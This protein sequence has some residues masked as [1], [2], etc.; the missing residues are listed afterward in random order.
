MSEELTG[1]YWFH[2]TSVGDILYSLHI[3]YPGFHMGNFC[4]RNYLK[5]SYILGPYV[6]HSTSRIDWISISSWDSQLICYLIVLAFK[7]VVQL[8]W[9]HKWIWSSWKRNKWDY[10][11]IRDFTEFSSSHEI[12]KKSKSWDSDFQSQFALVKE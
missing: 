3:R 11:I 4:L 2:L 12:N 6:Y 1:V 5:V 7:S 9:I 10:P 8:N